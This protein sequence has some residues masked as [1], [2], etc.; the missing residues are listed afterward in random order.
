MAYAEGGYSTDKIQKF[1]D[2]IPTDQKDLLICPNSTYFDLYYKPEFVTPI[3]EKAT[4]FLKN[5]KLNP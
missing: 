3:V 4:D 2:D 1:Y 5:N